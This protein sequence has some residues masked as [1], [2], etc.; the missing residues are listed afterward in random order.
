MFRHPRSAAIKRHL[1]FSVVTASAL[2]IG[3]LLAAFANWGEV[4]RKACDVL[5]A[6]AGKGAALKAEGNPE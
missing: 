2:G 5:L 6:D 3:L 4:N 1:S